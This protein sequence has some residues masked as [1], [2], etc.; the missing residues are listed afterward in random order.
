MQAND[1]AN[2]LEAV[3][4]ARDHRCRRQVGIVVQVDAQLGYIGPCERECARDSA[5]RTVRGV[6]ALAVPYALNAS[7]MRPEIWPY[8]VCLQEW[9]EVKC[10]VA[11]HAAQMLS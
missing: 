1:A 5:Q 9:N 2:R 6:R 10:F 7:M 11:P 4:H 3:Q 8:P